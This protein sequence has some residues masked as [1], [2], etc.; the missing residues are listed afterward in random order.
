MSEPL[1]GEQARTIGWIPS[2]DPVGERSLKIQ[3]SLQV[4]ALTEANTSNFSHISGGSTQSWVWE[5][6]LQ[7]PNPLQQVEGIEI[8][9]DQVEIAC[10]CEPKVLHDHVRN[11]R[12][13][14]RAY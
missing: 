13:T 6:Y 14:M 9:A 7:R 2:E 11:G 8:V 5:S 1:V 4:D 3:T 12:H 10:I